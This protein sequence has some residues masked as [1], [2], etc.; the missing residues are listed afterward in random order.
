MDRN[1][2]PRWPECAH[3][4]FLQ[5]QA[6][7]FLPVRLCPDMLDDFDFFGCIQVPALGTW[8]FVGLEYIALDPIELG[9]PL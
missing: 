5:D 1:D 9:I 7:A 8:I 4:A 3:W 2:C 6:S